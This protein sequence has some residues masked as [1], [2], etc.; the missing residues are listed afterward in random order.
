MT[1]K[2]KE[3]NYFDENAFHTILYNE[4]III[5]EF[6]LWIKNPDPDPQHCIYTHR[7]INK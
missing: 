2:V 3:K 4:K 6:F 1:V 7:A 5:T